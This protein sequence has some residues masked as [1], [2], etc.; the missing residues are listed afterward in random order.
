MHRWLIGFSAFLTRSNT[1][2]IPIGAAYHPGDRSHLSILVGSN[3]AVRITRTFPEI[4]VVADSDTHNRT[5]GT[6]RLV[7]EI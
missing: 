3:V 1:V 6:I 2:L 5:L 7:S 4:T